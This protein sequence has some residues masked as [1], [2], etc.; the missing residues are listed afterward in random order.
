MITNSWVMTAG[1]RLHGLA[2]AR[3]TAMAASPAA[4]TTAS[5]V[6]ATPLAGW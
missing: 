2:L 5:T 1:V 6:S 3:P 4:A